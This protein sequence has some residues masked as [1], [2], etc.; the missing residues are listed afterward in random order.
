[1]INDVFYEWCLPLKILLATAPQG[2]MGSPFWSFVNGL[3]YELGFW[4]Q[5]TRLIEKLRKI[6]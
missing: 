5:E 3:Q 2:A 1:M 4:G 6:I